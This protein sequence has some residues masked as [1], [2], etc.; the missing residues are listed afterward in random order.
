MKGPG[1]TPW[2]S[3]LA[4]PFG[5][6]ASSHALWIQSAQDGRTHSQA[7]SEDEWGWWRRWAYGIAHFN[8]SITLR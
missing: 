3:F 5:S 4:A 2:T 1:E 8:D 7:S 6:S